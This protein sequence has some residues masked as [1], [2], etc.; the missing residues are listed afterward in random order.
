MRPQPGQPSQPQAHAE[1]FKRGKIRDVTVTDLR[2]FVDER[3]WLAELFRH[4]ELTEQFYPQMAYISSTLPQVTR[5]P[6]E[7][8]DQADLFCFI[9]PSNFKI[10]LWDNRADS[11]TYRHVMT[12][13]VGEDNP[14][15][16]LV[17]KGVVHAYRNI[18]QTAGIVINCPNRLYM[19]EG[20]R[21]EIDE[22]RHEDDP[23]T[24]FRIDD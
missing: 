21:A 11:E 8:V 3:G 15:A 13:F 6:H 2:K 23:D 5:G 17:P 9:G 16:V 24:I 18:G 20:K 4:D 14:K 12:L 22:I 10:R 7:H 1:T 19:G